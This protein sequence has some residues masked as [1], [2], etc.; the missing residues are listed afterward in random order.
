MKIIDTFPFDG[1]WVIKMRLEFLSPYVDEFVIV[2]AKTGLDGKQKEFM[3]KDEWADILKPYESKIHW[4]I[5]D[6]FPTAT[7]RW[8]NVFKNHPQYKEDKKQ[9]FFNEHYQRDIAI[10]YIQKKYKGEDYIVNVGDIG[11]IPNVDIF[12]P[13]AKETML[14]KLNEIQL[15]LYMEMSVF[16]YN[17]YWKKSYNDYQAYIISNKL[18]SEKP[19]LTYWR[20]HFSSNLMLKTAGW[21]FCYFME[22]PDIQRRLDGE[23]ANIE[24]IK[25]CIAQGKD[26]FNRDEKEAL[27]HDENS[28]FPE[29]IYA[30]RGEIDY[31]Q[32]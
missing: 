10:P 4:V 28:V 23:W 13:D 26:I 17:F 22:I 20:L 29:I 19:S 30:Y 11:E 9:S 24:H 18:L 31:I 25:E 5:I 12:H 3:Y 15:P 2:E 14:Q 16:Y 7:E 27:L 8:E 21:C 6:K 1:E 32:M